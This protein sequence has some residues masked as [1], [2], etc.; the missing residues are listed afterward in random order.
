MT[1][2]GVAWRVH[3][4]QYARDLKAAEPTLPPGYS[5]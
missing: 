1:P 4:T 5:R 3:L 2:L